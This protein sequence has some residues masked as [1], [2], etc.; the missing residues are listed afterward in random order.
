VIKI[1]RGLQRRILIEI[2]A[3]GH[4]H[5]RPPSR[6]WTRCVQNMQLTIFREKD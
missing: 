2:A 5:T 4:K 3:D 1:K 6:D